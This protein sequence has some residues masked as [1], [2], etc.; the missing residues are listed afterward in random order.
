M[1]EAWR[2]LEGTEALTALLINSRTEVETS[3]KMLKNGHMLLSINLKKSEDGFSMGSAVPISADG[4]FLT[5]AHCVEEPEPLTL[6][7]VTKDKSLARATA[8]IV[9]TA[10]RVQE[11]PD[12]A[13]IHADIQP[14]GFYALADPA[15]V[16]DDLAVGAGAW[17][18]FGEESGERSLAAGNILSV[19]P[20]KTPTH[21]CLGRKV[22]HDVPLCHGDSGGPLISPDGYLV[23][24][25]SRVGAWPHTMARL[26]LH[27]D[28]SKGKPLSGYASSGIAPD[29]AWL[30]RLI[31]AD[32]AA[33]RRR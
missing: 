29:A 17:S 2:N 25:N 22:Y 9:W 7:A 33:K 11:E 16:K 23:A 19:V 20:L 27:C 31:A 14:H 18:M 8:R 26:F 12:L 3:S 5:A 1:P 4:Y 30:Q 28:G 10:G 15:K 32:R 21:G 13:L 24:I 6:V